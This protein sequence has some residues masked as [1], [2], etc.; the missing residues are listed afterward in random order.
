MPLESVFNFLNN[1]ERV[2]TI[3]FAVVVIVALT[4]ALTP[5]R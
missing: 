4:I 2:G 5:R 3:A 1:L